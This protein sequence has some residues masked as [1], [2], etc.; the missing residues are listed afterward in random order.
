MSSTPPSRP[1]LL[2]LSGLYIAQGIPFGFFAQA[3]PV[4]LR[5]HGVSLRGIA[6]LNL[7]FFPWALKFLWAPFVDHRGSRRQWLLALQTASI[8][9]AL[10]L[11]GV[12][13]Q[14]EW[15]LVALALLLFNV[16]ASVQ[17]IATDGLAILLLRTEHRGLGN[18]IQVGAYR[19]GMVLGGG[20]L[21]WVYARYGWAPMCIGMAALLTATTLP[22]LFLSG[23][24]GPAGGPRGALPQ[25]PPL[26]EL[27]RGWWLR[28]RIP[29]MLSFIALICFYKFGESMAASMVGPLLHDRGLSKEQ[30]A[31][32]RGVF[33]TLAG[34][35]GAGLGAALTHRLSRRQTLLCG[36]LLQTLGILP[37]AAA[38]AGLGGLTMLWIGT[39]AEHLF[40]GIATVGLF[41]L[42]MDA[43]DPEHAGTDYTVL[44]CAIVITQG[45]SGLCAGVLGDLAGFA[46]MLL[47]AALLSALGCLTL[48]AKMLVPAASALRPQPSS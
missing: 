8:V 7:L 15:R 10:L 29:G 18:G 36:G 47:C 42:M 45:V 30:I 13:L 6:V 1:T 27:L 46:P 4:M 40:A 19:L 24:G 23:L 9:G 34:L 25:R 28:L 2:L 48:V 5:E 21:L 37:Y 26:P 39:I 31:A 33:G 3:M 35:G 20:L 12:E 38:A 43:S 17:D 32:L 22:V 14:R 44:S 41:A 16:I 11:A